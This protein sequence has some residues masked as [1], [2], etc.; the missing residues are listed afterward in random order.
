MSKG[1]DRW[2]DRVREASLELALQICQ[3]LNLP[4]TAV[5]QPGTNIHTVP[6]QQ[7]NE[8]L[9]AHRI[10]LKAELSGRR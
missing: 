3:V 9:T 8:V 1:K 5:G 4:G 7:F 10:L 6:A 2:G